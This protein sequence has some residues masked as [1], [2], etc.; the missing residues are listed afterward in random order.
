MSTLQKRFMPIPARLLLPQS[1]KKNPEG[2]FRPSGFKIREEKVSPLTS[3]RD[4]LRSRD[5]R[6]L[7]PLHR[8]RKEG[9]DHSRH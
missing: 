6:E 3:S 8:H 7:G 4:S 1:M 5:C 2:L 9:A